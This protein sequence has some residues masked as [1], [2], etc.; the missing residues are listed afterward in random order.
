MVI[1]LVVYNFQLN[2]SQSRSVNHVRL[3]AGEGEVSFYSF[4]MARPSGVPVT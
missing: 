4:N 3:A 2:Y 1:R